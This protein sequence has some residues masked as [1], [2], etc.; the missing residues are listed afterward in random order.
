MDLNKYDAMQQQL[1]QISEICLDYDGF[2]DAEDL[3]SLI[4]EI[5]EMADDGLNGIRPNFMDSEK[6]IYEKILKENGVYSIRKFTDEE[7][8][9]YT[10]RMLEE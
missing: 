5:K 4:D 9:E 2:R 1:K 8:V 3:M 10:K 7:M 6:N